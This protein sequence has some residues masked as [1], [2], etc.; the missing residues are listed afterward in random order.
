MILR[1]KSLKVIKNIFRTKFN[2]KNIKDLALK[3]AKDIMAQKEEY[4][5]LMKNS[6]TLMSF[7]MASSGNFMNENCVLINLNIN[8]DE[9]VYNDTFEWATNNLSKYFKK[10]NLNI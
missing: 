1:K 6:E 7:Q 2:I 8:Q 10:K 5:L 4:E 3:L 9:I